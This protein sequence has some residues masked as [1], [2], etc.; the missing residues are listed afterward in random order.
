MSAG[1]RRF[2]SHRLAVVGLA[3]IAL[4]ILLAAFAAQVAP[5]DPIRQDLPSALAPPSRE[6]P[7]GADE[8]GRDR[9][10]MEAVDEAPFYAIEVFP[11]DLGTKG[12][13]LTDAIAKTPPLDQPMMPMRA[14]ST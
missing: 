1:W 8:F 5:R 2:V 10:E 9:D 11:G 4:L 6:F 13:L 3:L 12:G 7:L 14:R